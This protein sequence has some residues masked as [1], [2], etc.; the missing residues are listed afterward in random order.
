ML[1]ARDLLLVLMLQ[2][3]EFDLELKFSW[4][5]FVK[6]ILGSAFV[7]LV[8]TGIYLRVGQGS[9]RLQVVSG[10]APLAREFR[11]DE[12]G[13]PKVDMPKN[14]K[15]ASGAET[16]S[17]ALAKSD[18]YLKQNDVYFKL[19]NTELDQELRAEFYQALL[20]RQDIIDKLVEIKNVETTVLLS[21]GV[22]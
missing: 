21:G 8:G 10:L 19:K 9:D 20:D 17:E 15:V 16:L 6:K 18:L 1:A 5:G 13:V 4:R 11:L 3:K 2:R 12:V 7:L 22:Q 14:L